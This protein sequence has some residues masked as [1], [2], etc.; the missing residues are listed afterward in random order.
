M[1]RRIVWNKRALAYLQQALKRI[2]LESITN[3]EKVER[4][5]LINLEKSLS[6][7]EQ[8]PADKFKKNNNGLFRAFET[9]GYR[10]AYKI[11]PKE[12]R[13]LRIRHIKQEPR[14]Y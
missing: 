6:N 9:H 12:I 14:L 2:S 3:A 5:I 13:V 4:A 10:V 8:F 11:T 1:E 7:P